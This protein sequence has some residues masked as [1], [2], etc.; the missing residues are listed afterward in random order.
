MRSIFAVFLVAVAALPAWAQFEPSTRPYVQFDF[1]P[2]VPDLVKARLQQ[3]QDLGPLK[4][5]VKQIL[6]NPDQFPF[7][8]EQFKNMKLDDPKLKRAVENWAKEDPSL[9]ESLDA[10]LKKQPAGKKPAD[11]ERMKQGLQKILDQSPSV[12]KPPSVQE[13]PR[14]TRPQV[15]PITKAAERVMKD[16]Q[17]GELGDWLRDSPAVKQA[18]Q[19]M[20]ASMNNPDIS[21]WN[22]GDWAK[23][24]GFDEQQA[25]RL[26]ADAFR[27]LQETPQPDFSRRNWRRRLPG[28]NGLPALNLGAPAMPSSVSGPSLP[29]IGTGVTWLL[30]IALTLLFGWQMLRWTKRRKPGATDRRAALGPWPVRPEA[31]STRMELVQAFDYL[32]LLTL[33]IAV[34][35]WNHHAVAKRWSEQAPTHAPAAQMLAMLYEASRY[36]DVVEELNTLQR[37]QARHALAQLAEAL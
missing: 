32:A 16:A 30:L 2:K 19:D 35:S 21:D 36:T 26:G 10:W 24:F 33:G 23:R 4:E 8:P 7:D 28:F 31:V 1:D 5:L 14:D 3:E 17:Q 34:T 25:W 15:N 13:R 20:R 18:L 29:T 9:K 37:E 12:D 6:A 22:T 11:L 27:R